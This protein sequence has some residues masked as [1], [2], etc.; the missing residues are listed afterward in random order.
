MKVCWICHFSNEGVRAR[1]PLTRAGS[2]VADFA[3]WITNLIQEFKSFDDVELHVIA[4]HWGL[5]TFTYEYVD[6]GVQYHFFKTEIPFLN[7]IWPS[8]FPLEA[9]TGYL[10]NRVRVRWF[11]R[12]IRPDLVNLM[13]AEN[14][15]YSSTVLGI[16]RIPVLISI[17]GIYS[18]PDRF[19][20][21]KPN[22]FLCKYERLVH[23]ENRYFGVCAPFMPDLIKR[24]SPNPVL[25]WHD[26]PHKVEKLDIPDGSQKKYDFVFFSRVT[27]LKGACDILDA[28]ALVKKCN[29]VVKLRMMGPVSR[30]FMEELKAKVAA[31]GLE[32]NVVLSGEYASHAELLKEASLAKYY[33]LPTRLDTLPSTIFEAIHLGLPVVSY[34][35]GDIPVLNKGDLRVLLSPAA[36]IEALAGNM[37]RLLDDPELGPCLSKKARDFLDKHFDNRRIARHFVDQYNAVLGH[38][39]RQ[40][41]VPSPLLY[42]N[43]MKDA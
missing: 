40:E 10:W 32:G 6:Q 43:Y 41:E 30:V 21:A 24:D 16:R 3:P 26:F 20:H 23:A 34:K 8:F 22:P 28:L 11:L 2:R 33:V 14:A 36:N 25:F 12:K 35:T 19:K 15:Y 31:L 29:P 38:Y 17:Q 27:F 42:E 13:G 7:R 1:L 4:P 39:Y 18:N 5:K 9:W 37:A